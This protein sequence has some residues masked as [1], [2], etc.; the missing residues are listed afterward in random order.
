MEAA[1]QGDGLTEHLHVDDWVFRPPSR[2]STGGLVDVGVVALT[3]E[4][5]TPSWSP[6]Q[7]LQSRARPTLASSSHP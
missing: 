2:M 7:R 5:L 1:K 4:V 6:P 3:P